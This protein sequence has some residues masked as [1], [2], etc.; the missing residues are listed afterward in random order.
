MSKAC[1]LRPPSSSLLNKMEALFYS[2]KLFWVSKISQQ[3][4]YLGM[5]PNPKL[6]K[7]EIPAPIF[8]PREIYIQYATHSLLTASVHIRFDL[9]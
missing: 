6:E 3:F 9:M 7:T 4:E 8:F 5:G 1:S 2:K